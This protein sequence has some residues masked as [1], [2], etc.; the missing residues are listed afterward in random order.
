M[1]FR[2]IIPARYQSSRLPAKLLLPLHGKPILQHTYEQAIRAGADS[3]LIATDDVRI[4]AAA[5]MFQAPTCLTATEHTSGTDRLA[6]AVQ[7]Q[8]YAAD[9]VIVNVQGDEPLIDPALIRQVAD[10]LSEHVEADIATLATTIETVA[11]L[12]NPDVVKVVTDAAG[13]ALMF[14]R[15]PIPWQR[16]QF[17]DGPP[18]EGSI[19]LRAHRRHIGLYAYRGQFLQTYHQ[20]TSCFLEDFEKLEQLRALWHGHRL[21]V[22]DACAPHLAGVDSEADYQ[23]VQQVLLASGA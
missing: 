1:A 15:A 3:V 2:I 13:F 17:A 12:F 20:L 9:D 4:I 19:D 16:D 11:D 7:R 18:R 6:E 22:A 5:E 14:S 8:G 10:N 23:R 21:H